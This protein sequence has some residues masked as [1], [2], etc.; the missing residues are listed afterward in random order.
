MYLKQSGDTFRFPVLPEKISVSYG[1]KNDNIRVCGIG[2]VT[3][4]QD[5]DAATIQFESFF[6]KTYFS[7]CNYRNIP[8]P[9]EA[10]ETILE[11][12]CNKTPVRFTKTGKPKISMY[13]TIE[14]FNHYEIGGDVGTIYYSIKLKEYREVSIRQIQVNVST[15]KATIGAPVARTDPTPAAKTYTVVSG[16]CLWNIAKKFYGNG[17][18]YTAIYEANKGVI[19]GNPNKIFPGQVFT[20]P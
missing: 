17:T 8:N 7:G 2:E 9:K 18:Q 12:M 3:I 1:S 16:D 11:M 19:G 20:I 14:S 4:I 13:M 5:S 10:V 6:P 15:Q